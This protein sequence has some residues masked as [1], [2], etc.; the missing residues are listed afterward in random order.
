[1]G[2]RVWGLGFGVRG[3]GFGVGG[4]GFFLASGGFRG[5]GFVQGFFRVHGLGSGVL[6]L[7]IVGVVV[8]SVLCEE[9][10]LKKS[11]GG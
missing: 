9:M 7:V 8:H 5:S 1:M 4:L 3:S 10:L 11:H 6:L 2:F